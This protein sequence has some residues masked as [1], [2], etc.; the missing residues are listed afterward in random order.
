[1]MQQ[2]KARLHFPMN[3]FLLLRGAPWVFVW[4]SNCNGFVFCLC[5]IRSECDMNATTHTYPLACLFM[6]LHSYFQIIVD[7]NPSTEQIPVGY[8]ISGIVTKGQK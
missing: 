2:S 8:E 3:V 4:F 7:L 1:M 5:C 6:F